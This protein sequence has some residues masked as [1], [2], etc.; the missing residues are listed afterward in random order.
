ML[1]RLF[2][3]LHLSDAPP[4]CSR[5]LLYAEKENPFGLTETFAHS[6][7]GQPDR[8]APGRWLGDP[9]YADDKRN[10]HQP[11]SAG[12]RNCIGMNLA[13][14]EMRL[15]LAKFLYHFDLESEVGPSWLDQNVFVI[16]D[17]KPL[18]CRLVDVHTHFT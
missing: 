18:M 11:F 17:R 7:G 10:A 5:P 1:G 9:D 16:W 6:S 15:I 2:A 12:P 13:W 4:R 14:H 3:R 8:F